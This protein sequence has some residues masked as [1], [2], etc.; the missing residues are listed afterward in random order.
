MKILIVDDEPKTVRLLE[1]W[2]CEKGYPVAVA[3]DGKTALRMLKEHAYDLMFVDLNLP[4]LTGVELIKRVK[5]GGLRTKTVLITGYPAMDEFFART[6]GADAY[7]EKPFRLSDIARIIQHQ[8][9][10]DGFHKRS[11]A[12]SGY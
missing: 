10:A 9:G 2:L 11:E 4:E 5:Q 8:E 7:L 3:F 1:R 12:N 6:M